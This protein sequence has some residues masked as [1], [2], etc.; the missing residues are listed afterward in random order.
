LLGI[1]PF[2]APVYWLSKNAVLTYNAAYL[3]SFVHA[4]LAM[5]LLVRRLTGRTDVALI[6]ALAFA[7]PLLRTAG[8][9]TFLHMQVS[10]WVPLCFWALHRYAERRRLTDALLASASFVLAV[11][12]S[13]YF[14]FVLLVPLGYAAFV[15][16]RPQRERAIDA[17]FAG[18]AV[19]AAALAAA[20]L[21]PVL[22]RYQR[23]SAAH[24]FERTTAES[25]RYS[26]DVLSYVSVWHQSGLRPFLRDERTVVRALFPGFIIAGLAA[27]A[28]RWRRPTREAWWMWGA[29]IAGVALCGAS[30]LGAPSLAG[31]LGIGLLVLRSIAPLP[32]TTAALYGRIAVLAFLLSLGPVPAFDGSAIAASGPHAWLIEQI[33]GARGLRMPAR[34]GVMVSF[35]LAVLAGYG[36]LRVLAWPTLL[37]RTAPALAGIAALV[38]VD[39]YAGPLPIER[40]EARGSAE[41][42]RVH[43]WIEAQ[44][45]GPV[46]HLPIADADL[47]PEMAN[48]S[49]QLTFHYATLLHGQPTVTG[50]TDFMPV[51][52]RWLHGE[53]SPFRAPAD[54]DGGFDM[55]RRLG[56]R[57]VL[58]HRDEF[59]TPLDSELY[60]AGLVAARGHVHSVQS[61]DT[62]LALRLGDPLPRHVASPPPPERGPPQRVQCRYLDAGQPDPAVP[63]GADP[64]RPSVAATWACTLPDG[65]I[66]AARWTFDLN[67]PD[68]WPA[69]LR[70]E[71]GPPG[72]ASVLDPV[73]DIGLTSR[74]A[75]AMVTRPASAP[76]IVVPLRVAGASTLLLRTWGAREPRSTP[77]FWLEVWSRAR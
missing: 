9:H 50:G 56:V 70:A 16:L 1:T 23:V 58:L 71:A 6:A 40:I 35:A 63:A 2:V 20:I 28:F 31:T 44:G 51:F 54:A 65:I 18:H 36:A 33:P 59:R 37:R 30:L 43:D 29:P 39:G 69:R 57:Y 47:R 10:G 75:D 49:V 3:A 19:V 64:S 24:G 48:A 42:R 73:L 14:A 27:A 66:D 8:Q 68:T 62:V 74:L 7:F 4:G 38:V 77:P 21:A 34:H 76:Q 41:D 46:M 55:L 25:A 72:A 61:F 13:L 52:A 45:P 5:W 11:L 60:E 17:R 15:L 67:R 26:A 53:G 22:L 32:E 12:T